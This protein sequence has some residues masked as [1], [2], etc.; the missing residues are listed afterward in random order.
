MIELTT[1][2]LLIRTA[3]EADATKFAHFEDKN[4]LHW[5]STAVLLDV[6]VSSEA[7][8]KQKIK[9]F[10]NQQ[11]IRFL[12]FHQGQL[13]GIS[14]FT[15]MFRGPFQACY[16]GYKIDRDF[17][18][19]G[20]MYEALNKAIFYMFDVQNMHRI[21]ANYMPTNERS[22]KL[23]MRLG[24]QKEGYAKNYLLINGKWE[25]H[26]LTALTNPNWKKQ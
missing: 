20:L 2:R 17:E 23:L 16:L 25:D 21:M 14:N 9:E 7:Y 22:E 1:S 24:F 5:A 11:S 4:K 26:I 13:I 18:G 8:W 3:H 19:Q 10:A 6:D 15:Q 12:I